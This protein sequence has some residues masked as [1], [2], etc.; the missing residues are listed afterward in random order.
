MG[1]GGGEGP[2]FGALQDVFMH[3]AGMDTCLG[4]FTGTRQ[5]MQDCV[6][7]CFSALRADLTNHLA[8]LNDY[9]K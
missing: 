6:T 2:I 8:L 4:E 9:H 3:R 1:M 5:H 7:Q